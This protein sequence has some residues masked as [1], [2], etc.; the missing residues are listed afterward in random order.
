[1][2]QEAVELRRERRPRLERRAREGMR[3]GEPRSVEEL[4]AQ[5][6]L[7]DAVDGV[8][9]DR[10]ADRGEMHSNLMRA[11]RL[12]V[13]SEERVAVEQLL[14]LEVGHRLTRV[15]RVEGLPEGRRAVAP[16]R[17]LDPSPSRTRTPLYEGQI[18]TLE[19]ALPNQTLEPFVCFGGPRNDEQARGVAVEPVHDAGAV[20]LSP[21]RS[22]IEQAVDER[23]TGVARGR[24]NHDARRL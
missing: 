5:R 1:L 4:T 11:P 21:G 23:S 6:R 16:D 2:R 7:G 19:L 8:T 12:E 14:D 9:H 10:Q 24:V 18:L 13:D 3:E 20:R 15:V 17:R 22:Q